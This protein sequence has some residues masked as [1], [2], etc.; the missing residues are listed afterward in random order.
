MEAQVKADLTT[1]LR[2]RQ[3]RLEEDL[4]AAK[5]ARHPGPDD[6][7]IEGEFEKAWCNRRD[8]IVVLAFLQLECEVQTS[9]VSKNCKRNGSWNH[10]MG[11][12]QKAG[13]LWIASLHFAAAM[14]DVQLCRILLERGAKLNDNILIDAY[15]LS[16]GFSCGGYL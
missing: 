3:E 2:T 1:T 6:F 9:A 14:N 16:K 7:D 11:H 13:G 10:L 15:A 5:R 8:E 12:A 4:E